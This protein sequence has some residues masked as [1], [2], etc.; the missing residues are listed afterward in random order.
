MDDDLVRELRT[1]MHDATAGDRLPYDLVGRVCSGVRRRR[2]RQ[3]VLSANSLAVSGVAPAA[4]LDLSP[5]EHQLLEQLMRHPGEVLSRT[6]RLDHVWEQG[7]GDSNV[8]D[9]YVR[10]LRNKIDRPYGLD[11]LA[12]VRGVGYRLLPG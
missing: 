2:Q 5:K 4:L 6:Y 1:Q 10:Y 12:T 9:V 11:T 7:S 8:V 3:L